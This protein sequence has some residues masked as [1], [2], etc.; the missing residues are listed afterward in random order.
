MSR[1]RDAR[2][3]GH[4][5]TRHGGR[6][7]PGNRRRRRAGL[8]PELGLLTSGEGHIMR[9]DRDGRMSVY[10]KDAG[11]NGLLFDRQGRLIICEPVKRR[12][13]RLET[14]GTLTVLTD[15]YDGKRYNQPND[16][17]I[18]SKGRVYFSD[19]RYGDRSDMQQEDAL[20]R[21]IGGFTASTPT[22]A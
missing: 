3:G 18:D 11:S 7:A 12:V 19:P 14:D 16:L 17:T 5:R 2:R 9:R 13:T 21:K 6:N 22:A 4:P 1:N 8:A 20:G 10:R 15:Q